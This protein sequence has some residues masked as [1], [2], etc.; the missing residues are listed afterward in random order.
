MPCGFYFDAKLKY[1]GFYFFEVN[2]KYISSNVPKMSV[3]SQVKLLIISTHEMKYFWYLPNKG[4]FSFYFF[5]QGEN[6]TFIPRHN[7]SILLGSAR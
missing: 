4:M 7:S 3:I 1:V 2:T 6:L 5:R